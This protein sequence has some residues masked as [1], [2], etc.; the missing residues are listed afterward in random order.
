[1]IFSYL[2]MLIPMILCG[3]LLRAAA[4]FRCLVVLSITILALAVAD[5]SD[6]GCESK[7]R[8]EGLEDGWELHVDFSVY[9]FEFV[10]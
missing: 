1:M 4:L 3:I 2:M 8:S 9:E 10:L 7:Q 5:G 6:G